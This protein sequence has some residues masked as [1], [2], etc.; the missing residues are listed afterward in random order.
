[1]SQEFGVLFKLKHPDIRTETVRNRLIRNGIV[2]HWFGPN[3]SFG[4]LTS[5]QSV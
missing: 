3:G 2:Y 4:E 5:L 1:M